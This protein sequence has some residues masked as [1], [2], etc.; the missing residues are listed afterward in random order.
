MLTRLSILEVNCPNMEKI[1]LDGCRKLKRAK[2]SSISPF[3]TTFSK[4]YYHNVYFEKYNFQNELEFF[5][6]GSTKL[7]L[8]QF[9]EDIHPL[10]NTP[11]KSA[12]LYRN[13]FQRRSSSI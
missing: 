5:H 6:F 10:E 2:V 7:K 3:S 4:K 12:D 8:S 11:Q 1:C 9:N 13:L